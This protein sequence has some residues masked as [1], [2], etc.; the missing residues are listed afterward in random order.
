MAFVVNFRRVQMR[1]Q[2]D[3]FARPFA[4]RQIE[5]LGQQANAACGIH[6]Q[7]RRL[8]KNSGNGGPRLGAELHAVGAGNF[9]NLRRSLHDVRPRLPGGFQQGIVKPVTRRV[10][11]VRRNLGPEFLERKTQVERRRQIDRRAGFVFAV[12]LDLLFD[13]QFPQ[14]RNDRRHERFADEQRRALGQVQDGHLHPVAGEQDGQRAGNRAA[15]QDGDGADFAVAPRGMTGTATTGRGMVF[16]LVHA[17]ED[18]GASRRL[19]MAEM[20]VEFAGRGGAKCFQQLTRPTP[21]F[22]SP[23]AILSQL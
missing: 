12:T 11:G 8:G 22:Y 19:A 1:E 2:R 16:R 3:V 20:P 14:H 21:P 9:F 17:G 15:A 6:N 10:V 7:V 13:S 18:Y 4:A 5:R 23:A